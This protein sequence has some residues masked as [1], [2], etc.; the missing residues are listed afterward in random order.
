MNGFARQISLASPLS[1]CGPVSLESSITFMAEFLY[2]QVGPEARRPVVSEVQLNR[3][4]SD[5]WRPILRRSRRDCTR[6]MFDDRS[7]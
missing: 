7:H 6:R 4:L 2:P 1:I 5:L 3:G